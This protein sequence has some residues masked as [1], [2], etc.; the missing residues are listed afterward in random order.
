MSS[1]VVKTKEFPLCHSFELPIKIVP[2]A[3][4]ELDPTKDGGIREISNISTSCQK[5]YQV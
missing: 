1:H 3:L 5:S 4:H 2:D